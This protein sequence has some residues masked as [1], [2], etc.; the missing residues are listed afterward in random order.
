M[1]TWLDRAAMLLGYSFMGVAVVVATAVVIVGMAD[2]LW[3]NTKRMN[4]LWQWVYHRKEF[5]AW[6]KAQRKRRDAEG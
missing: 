6:L 2:L 1:P 3:R 4:E 5:L